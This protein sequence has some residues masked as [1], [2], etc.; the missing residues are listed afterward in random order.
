MGDAVVDAE[1]F[2]SRLKKLHSHFLANRESS[3]G[4]SDVLCIAMGANDATELTYSKSSALHLYLLG[5]EFADSILLLT[6]TTFCFMA[7]TKK[8]GMIEAAIQT[9]PVEGLKFE[10]FKK[11]KDEGLNKECFHSLLGH[12]RKSGSKVGTL[13]KGNFPGIF[14]PTWREALEN[15]TLP[16]S[17]IAPYLGMYLASKD[18]TELVCKLFV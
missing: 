13:L 8:C 9:K 6:K 3:W 15:S 11:T 10:F 1:I 5:Y 18:E 2:S 16:L 12:I 7:T 14:I 4:G 17:E